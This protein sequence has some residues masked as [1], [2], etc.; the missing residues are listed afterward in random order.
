MQVSCPECA[1][2]LQLSAAK[3]PDHP[4]TIK[5]P[6]CQTD[7]TV[8]P[9]PAE[10]APIQSENSLPENLLTE[11]SL[12]ENLLDDD[13]LGLFDENSEATTAESP[14]SSF[15]NEAPALTQTAAPEPPMPSEPVVPPTPAAFVPPPV[16]PEPQMDSEVKPE[17]QAAPASPAVP[18]PP[19]TKEMPATTSAPTSSPAW[20]PVTSGV[21]VGWTNSMPTPTVED[22]SK[23]LVT[24][25]H[26]TH[27]LLQAL[28]AL[29]TSGSI[30]NHKTPLEQNR[31]RHIVACLADDEDVSK[32]QTALHG[33]PY[34]LTIA[35]SPDE[36][37]TMLQTSSQLDILLLDP[38]FHASQ[39]GGASIMRYL[40]MLNPSRR[41]RVFVV[42]MSHS[43]RSLDMQVAFIHGVNLVINSNELDTL[44]VALS[45]SIQ[46][47]NNL[48][49]AFNE[50]SG[51]S[52]F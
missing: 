24:P 2:R 38:N 41:R 33:Q 11:N 37:T 5:C 17:P 30:V 12:A 43:Y 36:V 18:E 44:P 51:A 7:F 6:R 42:V 45:K 32:V 29:L 9:A 46:E 1:T 31:H 28:A 16:S 40:N 14:V 26:P 48:Y 34:H 52:A 10:V 20:T 49:R 50:A 27:D 35:S 13:P 39:H 21:A 15:T 8:A 4:F 3:L 23:T 47:F 19:V 25:Q 22:D